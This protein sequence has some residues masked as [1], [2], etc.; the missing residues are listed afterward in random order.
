MPEWACVLRIH[1]GMFFGD[2]SSVEGPLIT[3]GVYPAGITVRFLLFDDNEAEHLTVGTLSV[4]DYCY[5]VFEL[6]F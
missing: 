5:A 6:T 4:F 1:N 3:V 2:A